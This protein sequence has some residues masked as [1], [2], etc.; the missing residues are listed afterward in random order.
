MKSVSLT[1][2]KVKSYDCVLISTNHSDYDY[3]WI[4]KNAKLVVDTRNA[5]A[6]VKTGRSKIVKA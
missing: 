1:A 3:K 5:T 2:A 4:V 6:N